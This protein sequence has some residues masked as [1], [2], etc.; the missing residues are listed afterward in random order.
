ML[1]IGIIQHEQYRFGIY[2]QY[3]KSHRHVEA[4]QHCLSFAADPQPHQPPPG[5]RVRIDPIMNVTGDNHTHSPPQERIFS[6]QS[7][8]QGEAA[9][10]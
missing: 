1:T 6:S 4:I 8:Q 3:P 7:S 10:P 2:F 9:H 5:P